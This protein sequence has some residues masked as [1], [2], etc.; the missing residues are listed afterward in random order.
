MSEI[1]ILSNKQEL[2][3]F[4]L[5]KISSG[6]ITFSKMINSSG[7]RIM[8]TSFI[9]CPAIF[10]CLDA[11]YLNILAFVS[12]SV[13]TSNISIYSGSFP[14]FLHPNLSNGKGAN[15]INRVA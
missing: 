4:I 14:S 7:V 15:S 10:S 3:P 1:I 13:N 6:I 9:S 5:F 11:G 2:K 8:N 12:V